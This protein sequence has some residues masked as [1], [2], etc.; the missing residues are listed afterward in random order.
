MRKKS[1]KTKLK[2]KIHAVMREIEVW[3]YIPGWDNVYMVS[4]L[5]RVKSLD[6][7]IYQKNKHGGITKRLLKGRVLRPCLNKNRGYVYVT[8]QI[9]GQKENAK[10]HRLVCKSFYLNPHLKPDVNHIDGDKLNNR[11]D[12]LEWVTREEN[13]QH[14]L[15][16]GLTTCRYN[17]K[18]SEN[19]VL[20]IRDYYENGMSLGAITNLFDVTKATICRVVNNKVWQNVC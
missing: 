7:Y 14:A 17:A 8:L 6:R 16:N 11:A 1:E 9:Q 20:K 3:R 4:N 15:A 12:N 10:L 19:E 18:L 5:G 2:D 13:M